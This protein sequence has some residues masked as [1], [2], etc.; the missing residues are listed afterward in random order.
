MVKA[1]K[2]TAPAAKAGVI[3][4]KDMSGPTLLILKGFGE[5]YTNEDH[6][7]WGESIPLEVLDTRGEEQ[8]LWLNEK[9]SAGKAFRKAQ[10]KGTLD[11]VLAGGQLKLFFTPTV[12]DPQYTDGEHRETVKLRFGGA[13]VATNPD[14]P[15]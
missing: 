15:F 9:T 7:E 6:P 10:E 11:A 3:R 1:T 4:L 14:V 12:V 2:K 8:T 13:A 5:W